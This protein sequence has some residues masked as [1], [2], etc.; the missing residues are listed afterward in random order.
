MAQAGCGFYAAVVQSGWYKAFMR[1]VV[2]S[3]RLMLWWWRSGPAW[4]WLAVA[5]GL[6]YAGT[7]RSLVGNI[8]PCTAVARLRYRLQLR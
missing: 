2:C 8:W 4:S 6:A 7:V 1:P 5:S 3:V